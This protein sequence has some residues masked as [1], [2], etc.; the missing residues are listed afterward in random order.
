LEGVDFVLS[1]CVH[2]KNCT[3]LFSGKRHYPNLAS[4]GTKI[5]EVACG[6]QKYPLLTEHV[7]AG[8]VRKTMPRIDWTYNNAEQVWEGK[9]EQYNLHVTID[10]NV[11]HIVYLASIE[12]ADG[13]VPRAFA[14]QAFETVDEAKEWCEQEVR[15][16][17][18][19]EQPGDGPRGMSRV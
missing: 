4:L 12:P 17:T 18:T 5:A 14:P 11:E 8:N 19:G 6:K 2:R 15:N 16:R 9:A 13:S 1:F 3:R 10:P 7:I